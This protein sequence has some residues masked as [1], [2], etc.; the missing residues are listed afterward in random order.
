MNF[1]KMVPDE[2]GN[3]WVKCPHGGK[4]FSLHVYRH[5]NRPEGELRANWF[6]HSRLLSQIDV[7]WGP[8]IT[9]PQVP[10]EVM[11]AVKRLRHDNTTSLVCLRSDLDIVLDHIAPPE[12]PLALPRRFRGKFKGKPVVGIQWDEHRQD[13]FDGTQ[14]PGRAYD[15][16]DSLEITE[17]IDGATP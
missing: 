10:E 9:F 3:Y 12:V 11:E 1:T 2:P 5:C 17:W 15:V 14:Q 13:I 16:K 8:R 7:A 6:D 4:V